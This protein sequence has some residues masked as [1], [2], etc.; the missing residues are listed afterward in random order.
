MNT[1]ACL[2]RM[3]TVEAADTRLTSPVCLRPINTINGYNSRYP[4]YLGA[5]STR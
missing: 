2:E 5:N 4:G 1:N 3:E